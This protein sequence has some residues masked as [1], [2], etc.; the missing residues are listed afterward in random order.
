MLPS[1]SP[2][3]CCAGVGHDCEGIVCFW[4]LTTRGGADGHGIPRLVDE[5]SSTAPKISL[6]SIAISLRS[7]CLPP[8]WHRIHAGICLQNYFYKP[9]DKQNSCAIIFHKVVTRPS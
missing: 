6:M 1:T 3:G 5:P 2:L 4:W 9:L 7:S 8:V